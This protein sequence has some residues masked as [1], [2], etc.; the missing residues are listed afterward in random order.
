MIVA[1]GT[2]LAPDRDLTPGFVTI[3][4]G[5]FTA[6]AS[7]IPPADSANPVLRFPEGALIPGLI[8]LQINGAV[9]VDCL[10]ADP[11]DYETL[12]RYLAG[13]GVTGY[14]PTII[15]APLEEMRRAA[16]RSA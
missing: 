16:S 10:R 15:S 4:D 8:D 7:G 1:A 5:R 9:G 12:G 13:T 11:P 3:A 2:V 14:L 6:V